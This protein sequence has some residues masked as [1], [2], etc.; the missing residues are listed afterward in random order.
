V[1][2][3][4]R[5]AGLALISP[6]LLVIAVFFLV[7]LGL[8]VHSA[9]TDRAGAFTLAHFDKS[10]ELYT[11][12]MIFTL[13]IVLLSCALIA[14]VAIA[15]AGYLTLGENPRTRPRCAGST[16]GRCSSPSSSPAR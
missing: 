8:S 9:F 11:T 16:A 15:I 4:G 5:A 6:A 7:P 13:A 12:D 2:L 14:A 3:S 1:R 10:F